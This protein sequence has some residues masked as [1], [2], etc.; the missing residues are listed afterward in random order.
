MCME[1]PN[2]PF[3]LKQV[4]Q[5]FFCKLNKY[6]LKLTKQFNNGKICAKHFSQK[7]PI[8]IKQI[9]YTESIV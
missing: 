6:I 2:K 9:M 5:I 7:A 8:Y 3:K 4:K 1:K